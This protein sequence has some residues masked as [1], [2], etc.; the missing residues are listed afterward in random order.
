MRIPL[1][2]R[3]LLELGLTNECTRRVMQNLGDSSTGQELQSTIEI[4]LKEVS[5]PDG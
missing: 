4:E 1:F 2:E 3:K 5:T